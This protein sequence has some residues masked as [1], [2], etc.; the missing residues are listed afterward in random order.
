VCPLSSC[1]KHA[2]G[3]GRIRE[4]VEN[5]Q[6]VPSPPFLSMEE[7]ERERRRNFKRR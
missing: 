5:L 7:R 2:R 3:R 1:A 4:F 6:Y